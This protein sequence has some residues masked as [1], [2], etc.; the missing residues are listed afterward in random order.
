MSMCLSAIIWSNIKEVYYGTELKD[1][2]KIGFRNDHIYDFIRN[3][4]TGKT[5][6]I[7]KL[8]SEECIELFKEYKNKHKKIY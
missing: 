4:N 6:N 8:D 7:S 3:D 1:A 5:L 2:E